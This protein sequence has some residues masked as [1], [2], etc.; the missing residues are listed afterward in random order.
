MG[1]GK[2]IFKKE[3]D[4]FDALY[5]SGPVAKGG[6]NT[7][8]QSRAKILTKLEEVIRNNKVSVYSTRLVDE[9]KTF[10]WQGNKAQAQRGKNDDLVMSLAI[11]LWLYDSKRSVKT[12]TIDMN[13]AMLAGFAINKQDAPH[14]NDMTPFNKQVG[15]FTSR[16]MPISMDDSH[17]AISGSVDF[18]WLL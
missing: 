11:G 14:N 17:P 16:G 2:Y 18:K 8:A 6:F 1:I 4:K 15:I 13:A 7:N 3:K 10:V 5:G 9:L 12:K